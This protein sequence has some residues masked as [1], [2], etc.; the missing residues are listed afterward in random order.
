V[1]GTRNI[2]QASLKAKVRRLVHFSSIHAFESHPRHLPIDETRE[3]AGKNS[4]PYDQSKVAGEREVFAGIEQ[5]LDAVILNPT[6]VVGPNDFGPSA[7]GGVFLQLYRR[8][9][10]ALVEG[11][12]D[13]VDVR[14]VAEGALAAAEKGRCGERYILA[15]ERKSMREMALLVEKA[16]GVRA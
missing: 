1:L 7:V 4:P 13:W 14:D 2:V 9:L 12:F 16:T 15:G 6:G 8:Q 11:D 3:S 10:P 5:G